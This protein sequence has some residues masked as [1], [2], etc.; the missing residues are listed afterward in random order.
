VEFATSRQ[1]EVEDVVKRGIEL[2]SAGEPSAKSGGTRQDE[3][4]KAIVSSNDQVKS[5]P[6]GAMYDDVIVHC[7]ERTKNA[8]MTSFPY[9]VS[10]GK[11]A[12]PRFVSQLSFQPFDL[13]LEGKFSISGFFDE[14]NGLEVIPLPVEHGA[15]FMCAGFQ[16]GRRDV[17]V[18]ISDV[19]KIPQV[20]LNHLRGI[21]SIRLYVIDALRPVNYE[22]ATRPMVH[23]DLTDALESIRLLGKPPKQTLLVGM[24]HEF[25]YFST[26][27][28]LRTL[29]ADIYGKVQCAYDGLCLD[30]DL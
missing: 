17:V 1:R 27:E 2:V 22:K 5:H 12:V 3:A 29:P 28:M 23:F 19:S 24:G 15:D 21:P 20:T 18:Y 7:F 13:S 30:L 6:L 10:K 4:E 25:D 16:F 9:L 26:N 11:G 14:T 8:I